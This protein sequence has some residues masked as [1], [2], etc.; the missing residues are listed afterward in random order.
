MAAAPTTIER[1]SVAFQKHRR[2]P[3]RW[4]SFWVVLSCLIATGLLARFGTPW[5]RVLG[6]L[7]A[8]LS[9]LQVFALRLRDRRDFADTRRTIRRVVVP[10]DR[11]LGERALRAAALAE[12]AERDP[13]V[14]SSELAQLHFRRQLARVPLEVVEKHSARRAFWLRLSAFSVVVFSGIALARDPSRVTEGLDVLFARHGLAPVAMSWLDLVR[15]TVQPPAYLRAPDR[16]IFPGLGSAEALGST[17]AVRGLPLAN[18]RHLVLSDGKREVPFVDDGA[19]GVVARYVLNEDAQL[20]V[21]ARF[22]NVL[23]PEPDG[24]TLEAV[25]DAAPEVL[26][27]GAPDR[28]ELRDFDRREL[29]YEASDDHGLREIDLVMRAGGREDRRPLTRLD[30]ETRLE[31]GGYAIESSDPFL[32]RTF[33]PVEVSVEARDDDALS[34]VK[35]GKSAAITLLPAPVG[36]P[37]AERYR[38]L[39]AVRDALTD[40]LATELSPPTGNKDAERRK[41]DTAQ[42]A[43]VATQLRAVLEQ[44][45]AG[46]T[47]APGLKA[48]LGGQARVLERALPTPASSMRRTEDVLLAV[49]AALRGLGNRDAEAVSKHLGDAAEEAADGAKQALESERRQ[50]GLKRL[51]QALAVLDP[52]TEHLVVL[53]PIGRDVGSVAQGEIR[54]IKRAKDSGNLLATE[55]A[56]RHL[57]ARLRRPSPSFSSAGGGGVESGQ[58]QQGNESGQPSDADKK[59]DEL[60]GEL[61]RLAEEHQQEL[62][63]VDH[64]L[65]DSEK[66]VDLDD[67]KQEALQRA[68]AL[69]EKIAPL[70]QFSDDP[71]SARASGALG[72]E[73]A[74]SMAQSMARMALK[75]AVE[76]GRHARSELADAA[77]RASGSPLFEALDNAAL[78]E[79]RAELDRDLAWAE[80]SLAR[81]QKSAAEKAQTGLSESSGRE[82]GLADRAAN[83]SGRGNHGEIALPQDLAEAL[84]KAEGLMRDA[85]KELGA[86]HGEQGLSLQRDAQRLLEQTNSGQ[87]GSGE[88][89]GKDQSPKPT[90]KDSSSSKGKQMRTDADVPRADA[91]NHA[92]DFRRRVLDGLSKQKI[93]R[94]SDAVRRYAEGLLQ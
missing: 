90:P 38:A 39:L 20:R 77:K 73:H 68:A 89:D 40:L 80:Q 52:G 85:A 82:R 6:G 94:L 56:A 17:I 47:L 35:W 48:F 93:G 53:G 59:F 65:S 34:G 79:A 61:E 62:D 70:P 45:F 24:V 7:L 44:R 66:S 81:A 71:D 1:L 26:L 28:I 83:L 72:R 55:L 2:A 91:A 12:Q 46:L 92:D 36:E 42:T 33:L 74:E 23:I 88:S 13:R 9:V 60:V 18:G 21:A 10:V 30:G 27:E 84:G 19:G 25:P 51:D 63:R 5:L 32:R 4:L 11:N 22:G 54:R 41:S 8:L 87:S 58:G 31:R 64:N 69:R 57:A 37:E 3:A 49:D 86:G 50:A 16:A 75:D 78:G 67:L 29:R 15:V 43:A 14:G 76:S